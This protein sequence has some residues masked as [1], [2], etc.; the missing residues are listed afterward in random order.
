MVH[1]ELY[2]YMHERI[3]KGDS[4]IVDKKDTWVLRIVSCGGFNGPISALVAS[5]KLTVPLQIEVGCNRGEVISD[6]VPDL[7]EMVDYLFSEGHLVLIV[8]YL[9]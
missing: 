5:C 1:T 4:A 9:A 2:V 6:V 3:V 7:G 8:G